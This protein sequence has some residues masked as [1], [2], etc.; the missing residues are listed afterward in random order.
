MS[1]TYK[2]IFPEITKINSYLDFVFIF[3]FFKIS[4]FYLFIIFFRLCF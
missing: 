1:A 3:Y 4:L 2:Q